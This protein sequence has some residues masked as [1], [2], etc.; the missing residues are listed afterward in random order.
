MNMHKITV[1]GSG[2]VG[3]VT[4]ACLSNFGFE[5]INIDIDE[6]KINSLKNGIMPIYEP[7]LEEIVI[8]NMKDKRLN[9]TTD[10]ELGI[11]EGNV[12]FIAVGTPSD[13]NGEADLTYVENAAREIGRNIISYTVIVDKSTVPIGTGEK[14]KQWIKEEL[15][16][17]NY[18]CDFDV[19]SNPEFLREGSAVYD[20]MHPDRIVIGSE[21]ER[22]SNIIKEIYN[23]LYLNEAPFIET[24]IETAEMIKY[25]SNSFLAMKITFINEVANLCE[26]VG[27][28]VKDVARAMGKDGRIG[29]KFLNPGPGY[30]GSCFPKDTKAFALTAKEFNSPMTL[31][32]ATIKANKNQKKIMVKKIEDKINVDNNTI[33]AIL[34]IAFKP[35]TDDLREAPVIDIIEDLSHKGVKFKVYDPVA[36][37]EGRK[38][39]ESRNIELDYCEDEYST[40]DG[41]N[42]LVILTEWNQF[43]KLDLERIKHLL[44]EPIIFDYRNIYS[45][46]ELEDLGFTYV[47]V[48]Q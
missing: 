45:R 31:V 20:F 2:Y 15:S 23:V 6:V 29:A 24:N 38:Y 14:V 26:K 37:D 21:R 41:C 17:R 8:K 11:K 10:V 43:R 27:A 12:I 13:E 18:D 30:G 46:T 44:I 28:N 5:V 9:F 47:G 39:F 1:L 32:E 25:A 48:G 35:N 3:L 33:I 7:G 34:G 42:A 22:A 19:V 40:I 36:M 4:G 16:I